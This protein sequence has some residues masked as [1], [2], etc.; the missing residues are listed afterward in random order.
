MDFESIVIPATNDFASLYIE[1]KEPVKGFFHYDITENTVYE[2]RYN[3]LM[4]RNIDRAGITRVI[5]N[6]MM[7]FPQS[8][9]TKRSLEK[10]R[11]E[12]S[13]VVIGGQQAGLLTGPL[14]TIHKI[15]SIIKL[16]EEQESKLNKPVV[17][18][19]WIAG[20]DHD[21]LEINHVYVEAGKS[22]QK[23]SYKTNNDEKKMTSDIH[24]NKDDMFQYVNTV[25]M[26]FGEKEHTKKIL[27]SLQAGI[28][29][30]NSITDLFSYIVM[31][32]FK[33]YGLL[34]IDSADPGLRQMEEPFFSQLIDQNV[35]ITQAVLSQQ[36]EIGS[37]GF[38][39]AIEMDNNA[40]NLFVYVN[41]ERILLDYLAERDLFYSKKAQVEWERENLHELLRQNPEQF[42]NNVVTR[43]LMQEWLFPTLAFI[44][45]PGE[46]AYWGELKQAFDFLGHNMPPII[47]RM[48]MTFLEAAVERD[49]YD[50]ELSIEVILKN[51]VTK[52]RE[53]FLES[54]ADEE[55]ESILEQ[56]KTY[57]EKQYNSIFKRLEESDRGLLPLAKKNLSIHLKQLDFM[58]KKSNESLEI[59]HQTILDK[60]TRIERHLRP[61]GTPQERMWNIFYYLNEMGESFI[62]Q[63][64]EEKYVFDGT[65]KLIRI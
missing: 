11:N 53:L 55:L 42:S 45:G 60:Y 63:L 50:L 1:Q 26:H 21:F 37:H 28:M 23:I 58:E 51:G 25:F 15:I 7:K 22:L 57:L 4:S 41:N 14:Y 48:N 27:T 20:E 9:K 38:N 61:Q 40:A 12:Q 65:H 36:N 32:L 30:Y 13:V 3:D 56:A 46:I 6:Y 2:K 18:V 34:I 8:E 5:E 24:Y 33:D 52:N 54:V 10:L 64:M 29:Q 62:H 19:F 39:K 59:R 16:A 35:E 49:I 31:S 17:P 43:P 44:A 47:P